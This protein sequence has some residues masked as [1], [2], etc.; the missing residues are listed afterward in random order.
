[1]A[2]AGVLGEILPEA[3]S[4]ERFAALVEIERT[5]LGAGDADLRLAAL[6]PSDPAV[7]AA[8]SP[9]ACACPTPS[10]SGSRRPPDATPPSPP[11]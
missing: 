3:V 11:P 4:L 9:S 10:A 8:V 7:A 1:M 5:H 6:L 2:E